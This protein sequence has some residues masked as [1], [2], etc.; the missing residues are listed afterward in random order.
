MASQ[1]PQPPATAPVEKLDARQV[2]VQLFRS[3]ADD[4]GATLPLPETTRWYELV[5]AILTT[6][7][8]P[9]TAVTA[10]NQ[11][12]QTLQSANLVDVPMLA[13][14][15]VTDGE[16]FEHDKTLVTLETIAERCGLPQHKARSAITA[17][18]EAA[19]AVH[20][21]YGDSIQLAV[22]AHGSRL[23]EEMARDFAFSDAASARVFLTL[24]FQRTLNMPIPARTIAADA[25]ADDLGVSYESLIAA[26]DSADLHVGWL[27]EVLQEYVEDKERT[28]SATHAAVAED[29][30]G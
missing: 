27:D 4:T 28:A 10:A 26:A 21:Q 18:C 16:A 20:S 15:D 25:A 3:Y 24:W 17:V 8:E 11:I 30:D 7:G 29:T 13:G 14:L 6:F 9:D 5:V 19:S 2:V 12:A 22:R 23:L 1:H